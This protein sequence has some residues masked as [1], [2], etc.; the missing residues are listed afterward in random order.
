[1]MNRVQPNEYVLKMSTGEVLQVSEIDMTILQPPEAV[2]SAFS[3]IYNL[4]TKLTRLELEEAKAGWDNAM[5]QKMHSFAHGCLVRIEN[6][7]CGEIRSCSMANKQTCTTKNLSKKGGN[8]PIC[9]TYSLDKL[10]GF[11]R[12]WA[13]E[14][15]DAVVHAWRLGRHVILVVE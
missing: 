4:C 2:I 3:Q 7:V 5:K 14:L 1:M 12:S 6:H 13:A 9:W 8:F 11:N 10:N 15:C